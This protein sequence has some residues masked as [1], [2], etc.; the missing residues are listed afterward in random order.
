ME[1]RKHI[2]DLKKKTLYTLRKYQMKLNPTKYA[3]GVSI[4]KFL[5]F[6]VS[7]RGIEASPEKVKAI[8]NMMLPRTTKD[9]Q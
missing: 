5:R 4:G 6:M 1:A 7:H 8:L 3:F 2:D 9:I